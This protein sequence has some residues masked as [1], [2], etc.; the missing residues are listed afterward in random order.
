MT[1]TLLKLIHVL[2]AA[3]LMGTGAATA[4]YLWHA[5]RSGDVR[6]IAAAARTAVLVEWWFTIPT[7]VLQPLTGIWMLDLAGQATDQP[8]LVAALVLFSITGIIWAPALVLKIRIRNV[9][10]AASARDLS[11]PESC[12]R[13]MRWWFAL[14]WTVFLLTLVILALMVFRPSL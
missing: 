8:W 3:L 13:W 6:I 5:H 7:V 4:F 9:A 2:S 14:W 10:V 1:Y 11:L 12:H